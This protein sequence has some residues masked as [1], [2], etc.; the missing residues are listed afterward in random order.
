MVCVHACVCACVCMCLYVCMNVFPHVYIHTNFNTKFPQL[1]HG[2]QY[3]K[4]C[5]PVEQARGP[6]SFGMLGK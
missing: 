4:T 5:W 6:F 3:M 1:C 2:T